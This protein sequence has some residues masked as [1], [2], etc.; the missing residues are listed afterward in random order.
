MA[1]RKDH[2]D[3]LGVDRGASSQ[4]IRKAFRA[5]AKEC[6]P[7][8]AGP[9]G[10]RRFRE[11][12]EA[13]EVLSDPGERARYDRETGGQQARPEAPLRPGRWP[14]RRAPVAPLPEERGDLEIDV[15]LT[16]GEAFRGGLLPLPLR[17]VRRCPRCGGRGGAAGW[18]CR[19]CLGWGSV[20]VLR[21][22]VVEIP[23]G[24]PGGAVLVVR[25]DV[26]GAPVIRLRLSV[27]PRW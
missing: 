13:Y 5:R 25:P 8:C 1:A 24:V 2:Y 18:P 22:I 15:D 7:D 3:T 11:V 12:A 19:S 27:G 4:G 17:V 26:E 9:E 6:H 16:P 20:D 23:P 14:R 21:R 10:D